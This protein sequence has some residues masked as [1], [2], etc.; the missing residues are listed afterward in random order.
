MFSS[1]DNLEYPAVMN[2]FFGGLAPTETYLNLVNIYKESA[3][4]RSSVRRKAAQ[5]KCGRTTDEDD[6]REGLPKMAIRDQ[7]REKEHNMIQGIL[8][9]TVYNIARSKRISEERLG[10]ISHED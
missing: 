6:L 5:F 9:L 10:C 4:W 8:H 2:Y 7:N 1:I 3:L